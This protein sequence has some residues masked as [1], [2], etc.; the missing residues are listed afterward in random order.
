MTAIAGAIASA[1]A[2]KRS[3][4]A[5]NAAAIAAATAITGNVPVY[6]PS[7]FSNTSGVS[8][9]ASI[10]TQQAPTFSAL[11]PGAAT[12]PMAPFISGVPTA[13]G[14]YPGGGIA[15]TPAVKPKTPRKG[16]STSDAFTHTFPPFS[17]LN[18]HLCT[19][20]HRN[21]NKFVV[22]YRMRY[23][24]LNFVV[25]TTRFALSAY[26]RHIFILLLLIIP[27]IVS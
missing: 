4:S 27:L 5:M 3:K 15:L 6:P 13:S 8:G 2:P 18:L 25:A 7:T 19:P 9:A 26:Y 1:K 12:L 21:G 11:P 24:D 14:A 16:T 22:K 10:A 23:Y 20:D 17:S